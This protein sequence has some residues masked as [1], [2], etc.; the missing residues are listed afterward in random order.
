MIV[1]VCN[2]TVSRKSSFPPA[3]HNDTWFHELRFLAY[4][5]MFRV[6]LGKDM[7]PI[8][9]RESCH[10]EGKRIHLGDASKLTR[11]VLDRLGR[12]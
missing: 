11:E 2:D 9:R 3:E 1:I 10:G 12:G 7:P 8:L 4:G 5:A 6:T